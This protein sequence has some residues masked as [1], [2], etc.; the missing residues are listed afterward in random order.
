MPPRSVADFAADVRRIGVGTGDVVMAHA[1]V[2]AVGPLINGPDTLAAAL[3]EAIGPS[4]TLVVATDWE[5]P[6]QDLLDDDG[7]VP[8]P[9]REHVPPFDPQTSR[10]M[11]ENGV[12]AEFVRTTPGALRSGN[13]NCSVTAI[14]ARAEWLTADQPL[15]YGYGPGSPLAKLAEVG[16][17]VLMI[18]A[19]FD[20]MTLLHHAEHL[21]KVPGKR[22]FRV[23]VPHLAPSGT[24]WRMTEEY[25][26]SKAIVPG[27]PDDYFRQIVS[28]FLDTGSGSRGAIGEAAA[29]LVDAGAMVAFGARWIEEAV[30]NQSAALSSSA[31]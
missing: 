31:S 24:W 17:K 12:L 13:P 8:D 6:Y 1:S 2:R 15:D 30:R 16:G 14:G 27:F 7:R 5:A 21:A 10:A 28:A 20:T 4:G 26:S 3:L 11:R 25:E 23:E 9:W 18:G 19:P 29:T 22:V